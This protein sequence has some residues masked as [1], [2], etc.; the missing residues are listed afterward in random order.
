MN[1]IWPDT[2]IEIGVI[3]AVAIVTR[4]VL[5]RV[6]RM[7]IRSSA[8]RAERQRNDLSGRAAKVIAAAGA[9]DTERQNHRSRTLASMLG[10]I[11]NA[12]LVIVVA[13]MVLQA[14][15]I[16]I[17][18]ALASAGIGGI[19][20]GFGA[21]SLVKDILSGIFIMMEDQFGVGDSIDVGDLRGTVLGLGLRVTRIQDPHGEIWYVRNG[22]ISTLGNR[23]QGWSVSTV[24]V[25]V[26]ISQD[27]QAVISTLTAIC[28]ALDQDEVWSETMLESP[29]VLGLNSFEG[30]L[31]NYQILLKCPTDK[32][33][34]LER[35]LRARILTA[36][37][38]A[39][40]R[41]PRPIDYVGQ[42]PKA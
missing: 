2:V 14:V 13:F 20:I 23:T 3:L 10:S 41:T 8:R 28:I 38:A 5:M 36:F 32:Q 24:T 42:P 39:G 26:P 33:W 30:N 21:Q 22:E 6:I 18:P 35:E 37:D 29:V 1:I 7:W 19:A 12:L 16:N 9:M 27:P 4:G 31:A 25:P 11:L 40:I 34:G 15:G 17:A